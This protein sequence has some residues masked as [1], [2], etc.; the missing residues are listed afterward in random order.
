M[1]EMIHWLKQWILY[2]NKMIH[3]FMNKSVRLLKHWNMF[4]NKVNHWL[5]HWNLFMNKMIHW[6]KHWNSFVN[7]QIHWLTLTQTQKWT[8]LNKRNDSSFNDS[9]QMSEMIMCKTY[10]TRAQGLRREG[11]LLYIYIQDTVHTYTYIY[12]QDTHTSTYYHH[13]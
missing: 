6:L 8:K 9:L 10:V 2:M 12:M 7:D 5:K 4:V 13:L 11:A 3:S 1:S